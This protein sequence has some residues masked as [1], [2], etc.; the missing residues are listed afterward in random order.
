MGAPSTPILDNFSGTLANWTQ[1]AWGSGANFIISGG[2]LASPGGGSGMNWTAPF[3]AGD[4]EAYVTL[5][6]GPHNGCEAH[7]MLSQSAPNMQ[8]YGLMF[9]NAAG[10]YELRR[11]SDSFTQ[12]SIASGTR[13]VAA[14]DKIAIQ[15]IG[16]A[17]NLWHF[18]GS[19]TQFNSVVDATYMGTQYV[20]IKDFGNT[21]TY[22]D[23]GGGNPIVPP[24]PV[25]EFE[26]LRARRTSW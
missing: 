13:A 2:L 20:G 25:L 14:G 15:R 10:N 19:W 17:V 4:L 11:W 16:T 22:D 26:R 3:S 24:G 5:A 21:N 18:S 9:D 6:N 7:V 8:G 1:S 12:T 23:Y